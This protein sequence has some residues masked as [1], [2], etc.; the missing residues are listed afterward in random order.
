MK[1]ITYEWYLFDAYSSLM[2][3]FELS[4]VLP[5]AS[6]VHWAPHPCLL[7]EGITLTKIYKREEPPRSEENLDDEDKGAKIGQSSAA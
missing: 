1:N 3:G 4:E 7:D 6:R 5:H 2:R